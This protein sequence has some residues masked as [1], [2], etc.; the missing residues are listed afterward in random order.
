LTIN[1]DNVLNQNSGPPGALYSKPPLFPIM[2]N[3]SDTTTFTDGTNIHKMSEMLL[4]WIP[5]QEGKQAA[6]A[7][8]RL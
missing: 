3:T 4:P 5:G 6:L 8:I 7:I 2:M 1:T